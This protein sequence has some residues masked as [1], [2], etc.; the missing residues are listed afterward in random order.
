MTNDDVIIRHQSDC[1]F[2]NSAINCDIL[3]YY[4]ILS[5]C[6]YSQM[7]VQLQPDWNLSVQVRKIEN[8]IILYYIILYYIINYYINLFYIILY[9]FLLY[10]I[11]LLIIIY[12]Y[13][14]Y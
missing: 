10:Y 2:I 12:H 8:Y 6:W 1:N 4:S 3:L 11:Q 5:N 9:Y 14:I 7:T 13:V